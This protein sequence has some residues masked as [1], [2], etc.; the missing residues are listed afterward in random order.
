[1]AS[2]YKWLFVKSQKQIMQ[3]AGL[4]DGRIDGIKDK[5]YL[6]A[7]LAVNKKYLP[8][9]FHQSIYYKE[10]DILLRNIRALQASGADEYFDISEFQC[11]CK[12]HLCSGY[13]VVMKINLLNNLIKLRKELNKPITITC[14]FRCQ[15]YND[16][17][18]G[19]IKK[20]GH[21]NGTA[22]DMYTYPL[23]TTLTG[24]RKIMNMW[25]KYPNYY[26]AYC[27]ENNN[28]PN[29]G[30]ATHLEVKS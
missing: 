5:E 17:I 4:Y 1:M 21:I 3:K 19:S 18:K 7:I 14:G 8:Q 22:I 20:S 16:S 6:K 12:G 26:Y 10:T 29:M 23:S 25:R 30:N 9:K 15:K 13:P 2:V 28:H 11:N 27:N 24:R